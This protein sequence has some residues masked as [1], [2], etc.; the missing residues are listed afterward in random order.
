MT[1]PPCCRLSGLALPNEVSASWLQASCPLTW[2]LL[3]E[4]VS[5][6]VVG[7]GSRVQVAENPRTL[8]ENLGKD[9]AENTRTLQKGVCC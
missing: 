7:S 1:R 9:T 2:R 3:A 6:Q 8:A 5:P 4:S